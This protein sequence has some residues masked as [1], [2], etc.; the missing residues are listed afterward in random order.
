MRPVNLLPEQ[1]R[2]HRGGGMSGSAYVL[3]GLLGV[4]LIGLVAYVLT[5][6][7]LNDHKAAAA[8]AK[9]DA[10][11]AEARLATLGQYGD[12]A[13][14]AKSRKASVAQLAQGR[15][16]WERFLRETA[17]VL[18]ADA[19]L[20]SVDAALVATDASSNASSGAGDSEGKPGAEL[21]GCAKRQS[22]VAT[23][24][25][26]LRKLHRVNDVTLAESSRDMSSSGAGSTASSGGS[27]GCGRYYSFTVKAVFELAP[28]LP[29]ATR[30][31]SAVP[32]RLG[33]G[34]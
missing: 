3:V 1:H 18:P 10:R 20:T 25:V 7:Q 31:P 24:M 26:R 5:T 12:F 9:R 6:N 11:Q 23:L 27:D 17:H 33:G 22:D 16:D 15:F 19:W 14:V 2:P 30:G 29:S 13:K 4:L 21:V 28:E 32:A 8:D 34:S